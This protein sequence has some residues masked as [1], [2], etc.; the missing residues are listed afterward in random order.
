MSTSPRYELVAEYFQRPDMASS[1][2]EKQKS[3]CDEKVADEHTYISMSPSRL[4][5]ER[6]LCPGTCS[7]AG[8]DR[9]CLRL[10]F[11]SAGG[12]HRP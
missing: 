3:L 1:F 7:Q 9:Q 12:I 6:T 8:K 4:L 11:L 5:S 10:E 2:I